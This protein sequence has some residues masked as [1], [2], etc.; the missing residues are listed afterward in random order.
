MK[1]SKICDCC[2]SMKIDYVVFLYEDEE[3]EVVCEGCY[4]R[5]KEGSEFLSYGY[6]CC[7]IWK[8][9]REGGRKKGVVVFDE[10]KEEFEKNWEE[11]NKE[12][13]KN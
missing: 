5:S 8:I 12:C 6:R 9:V 2:Q 10:N 4:N 7:K 1:F 11:E 13:E 3:Y